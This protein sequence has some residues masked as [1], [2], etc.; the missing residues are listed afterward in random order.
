MIFY[1]IFIVLLSVGSRV[2]AIFSKK[3]RFFV[4]GRKHVF[5]D[6]QTYF[7]TN[8]QDHVWIHCA[9]LGEYLLSEPIITKIKNETELKVLVTFFSPSGYE[10]KKNSSLADAV[11]YMP[12]DT[13]SNA[14][15]F[16]EIVKPKLVIFSKYDFWINFINEIDHRNIP[17]VAISSYFYKQQLYFKPWGGFYRKALAKFKQFYVINHGSVELLKEKGLQTGIYVGDNRFDKAIETVSTFFK[18]DFIEEFKEGERLL[19]VGSSWKEDI[20]TIK[21]LINQ[22]KFWWKVI[23]APHDISEENITY[24]EKNIKKD[25]LRYSQS[26]D[27]CLHC[28]QVMIIDNIGMLSKLY[29]YAEVAFV[30]GAFKQGLHNII[31]PIAYGLPIFC[32]NDLRKFPE[33]IEAQAIGGLISINDATDFE[34]KFMEL[35]SSADNIKTINALNVKYTNDNIGASDKIFNDLVQKGFIPLQHN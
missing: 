20:D 12:I 18:N 13:K 11:F 22:K 2:G 34:Q 24:I 26:A 29:R 9:S 8:K 33:A 35:T 32:G 14:I 6:L 3:L 17:M 21:Q 19:L 23:I 28:H 16:L 10:N 30:G 15:K 1:N 5:N 4:N 25:T 31:E 7:D 27:K